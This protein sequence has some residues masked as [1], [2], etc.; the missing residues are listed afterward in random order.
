MN[1]FLKGGIAAVALGASTLVAM[2]PADAQRWGRGG[3]YGRG[4]GGHYYHRGGGRTGLAIGA[5]ILGLAAGA[6]IASSNANRG[7]YGGGGG[8][9]GYYNDPYVED[10]SYR[11]VCRVSREWDPYRERYV[12]VRYCR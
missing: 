3:Y 9:Y 11:E 1:A 4:Y 5:G 2:A 12:R 7:Y 8:S 10:Y 6:A